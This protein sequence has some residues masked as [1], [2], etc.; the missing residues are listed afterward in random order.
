MSG[1]LLVTI[2]T[3]RRWWATLPLHDDLDAGNRPADSKS[4]QTRPFC[5]NNPLSL[6]PIMGR[7]TVFIYSGKCPLNVYVLTL[8]SVDIKTLVSVP[9]M[10]LTCGNRCGEEDAAE[11][12]CLPRYQH[13]FPRAKNSIRQIPHPWYLAKVCVFSVRMQLRMFAALFSVLLLIQYMQNN[14]LGMQIL[15]DISLIV[16][17]KYPF[18]KD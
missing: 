5:I 4:G 1:Q 11:Y 3:W 18:E 10:L 6:R 17:K 13:D 15:V 8:I 9:G 14:N 16:T 12:V 7:L 2:Q